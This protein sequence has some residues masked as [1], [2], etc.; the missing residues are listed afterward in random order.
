MQISIQAVSDILKEINFE[1]S[2]SSTMIFNEIFQVIH[3]SLRKYKIADSNISRK[4]KFRN[5]KESSELVS[6]EKT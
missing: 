1:T 3:H 2:S 4:R 6:S 5:A